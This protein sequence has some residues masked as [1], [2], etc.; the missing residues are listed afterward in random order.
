MT[1]CQVNAS[2]VFANLYQEPSNECA[3]LMS[4][5]VLVYVLQI[6]A[7]CSVETQRIQRRVGQFS[8]LQLLC[9]AS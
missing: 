6:S 7:S 8:P 4:K 2:V 9:S 1:T 3:K 5:H